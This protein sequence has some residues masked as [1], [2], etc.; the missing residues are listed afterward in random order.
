M[1]D[2][3][4]IANLD[5]AALAVG[6]GDID[7]GALALPAMADFSR[8]PPKGKPAPYISQTVLG[9]SSPFADGQ[10][11]KAGIHLHWSLPRQLT[12]GGSKAQG[13]EF[14]PVPDRWLVTRMLRQDSDTVLLKSWVVES[15]RLSDTGNSD[16]PTILFENEQKQP[17]VAW[18]GQVF[19]AE[20]WQEALDTDG[21]Q[22][23]P[24]PFTALGYGEPS[25]AAFYPNCVSVF[26]FHDD[27]AD[28]EKQVDPVLISYQVSGWYSQASEDPLHQA[29]AE[30]FADWQAPVGSQPGRLI[31]AG[32]LENLAWQASARYLDTTPQA[33]NVTIAGTSR[34]ALSALLARGPDADKAEALFNALQFGWLSDADSDTGSGREFEQLVHDA[35]FATFSGGNS[36]SVE[37][38]DQRLGSDTP[39]LPAD[40]A[41]QLARLNDLQGTQNEDD[42]KRRALQAQLFLDWQKYQILLHDPTQVTPGQQLGLEDMRQWLLTRSADIS[43][44]MSKLDAQRSDIKQREQQLLEK[45]GDAFTLRETT[46]APRFYQPTEPILLLAGKDVVPPDRHA[47][48]RIKGNANECRLARQIRS[49][50]IAGI[51]SEGPFSRNSDDL[52]LL[53]LPA[54]LPVTPVLKALVTEA[55]ILSQ[56]LQ[57]LLDKEVLPLLP[58]HSTPATIEYQ[59]LKPGTG[60][61]QAWST[62]WL[63]FLLHYEI[64]LCALGGDKPPAGY[65]VDFIQKH[66]RFGFDAFDLECS[67]ST[68]GAK[69]VLQGSSLLAADAT[70]GLTREIERYAKQRGGDNQPLRDLLKSIENLPLLAQ[71]LTGL[72]D[73]LL[74]QRAALQL[75][76]DDPLADLAQTQLIDTVR[77]AVGGQT[78]FTPMTDASYTPLRAE[79]LRIHRLRLVDVFGRFKDYSM[80]AVQVAKGLQPP[81]GLHQDDSA[82]LPPRLAQ[83]ARLQF[84][85][86][87]ASDLTRESADSLDSGPVLGWVIP[88]HLERSLVLHAANGRPLGKLA[89]VEDKVHWSCAPLGGFAYGTPL[90]EVFGGQPADFLHFAQAL[91]NNTDKGVLERFLGPVDF[92]LRYCLPDQFAETAEHV[93]LSGQPLVLA[94]ASL[95]LELLG[96]PMG[97]QDW[98]TLTKSLTNP[99]GIDEGGLSKVRFPVRLGALNKLDDTL[100]GYWINP[101]HAAGYRDFKALYRPA[102]SGDDRE[103]DDPLSVTAD[104]RT[105]DLILLLDPR[106]SVHAS[107]GIL[108]AK[109]IDIPPKHYASTLAS[110]DVTFDCLPVLTGGDSAAPA[111]MVLPR[112]ASGEW[113]WISTTGK[114]WNSLAPSDINGARANLDYGHQGIAEGWLSVRRDGPEKP[115]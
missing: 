2:D 102:V 96:P 3:I 29:T 99:D 74:M 91:Y 70:L 98:S 107:C 23:A 11:L 58:A 111:S 108:P 44:L 37:R 34:E 47:P 78:R 51:G 39:E 55:L 8:L 103:T 9:G 84:R 54:Q 14:P 50:S 24:R 114:D 64:E 89:L 16:A 22:R 40:Q 63:P 88:N 83:P 81:P 65:P 86:R 77:G 18:I 87:S 42:R 20:T 109:T 76:V 10:P 41:R 90:E 82:L 95:A 68:L 53:Q 28:L 104:G 106:G 4:L 19:S 105:Q 46:G 36:W 7:A 66:F 5:I 49:F 59:G 93:V 27:L 45:L 60:Y 67:G 6:L 97:N 101:L 35:G 100:L 48:D 61:C 80:P 69:R 75:M 85:W 57:P 94:R 25:F 79:L 56:N 1:S 30:R 52:S 71:N 115:A 15:D 17:Q 38:K 31:C 32:L 13:L 33:L 110:L 73:A 43:Q 21:I 26:G 112:V 12:R 62:P 113:H 72:N 92:A